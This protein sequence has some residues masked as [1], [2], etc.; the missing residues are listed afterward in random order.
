MREHI[1]KGIRGCM[2]RLSRR[3]E[4]RS[5]GG[6]HHEEVELQVP[7]E[8]VEILGAGN[9]RLQSDFEVIPALTN[10]ETI[11]EYTCRMYDAGER[12]HGCPAARHQLCELLFI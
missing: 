2:I 7:G 6:E 11:V 3:T 4:N 1:H 8:S 12:R 10:Q 5:N 9:L